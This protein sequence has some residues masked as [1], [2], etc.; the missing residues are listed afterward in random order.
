VTGSGIWHFSFTVSDLDASIAFYELLG[1]ETTERRMVAPA[2]A[3]A[4]TG[5][6]DA[7]IEIAFLDLGSQ[8]RGPRSHDLE[9]VKYHAPAIAGRALP[10]PAPGAAHLAIVVDDIAAMAARLD[11]AGADVVSPPVHL[12]AGANAGGF[13]CYVRG[14]DGIT[15]E[16][17]QPPPG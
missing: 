12:T 13:V 3:P 1:F 15:H 9:L 16:L 6:P 2:V 4:L 5:Y 11:A 10:T 14:P 7:E 17:F 8:P